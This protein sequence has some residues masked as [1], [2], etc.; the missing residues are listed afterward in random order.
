M[1]NHKVKFFKN[2]KRQAE[3]KYEPY[4]PQYQIL[5]VEPEEFKSSILP[6]GS[7]VAKTNVGNPRLK[8]PQGIEQSSIPNIGNNMEQSWTSIDGEF[9]EDLDNLTV[10]H[11][12][13]DN[14]DYINEDDLDTS[15][16]D[17]Q[18]EVEAAQSSKEESIP[19]CVLKDLKD[20]S[21]LL[22]VNGACFCSGN[23][24]EIEDQARSLVF[25][26]HPMCNGVPLSLDDI[27][28]IK[29]ASIKVGLF[30]E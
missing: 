30:V 25:G 7:L 14:N 1:S 28:V 2:S 15:D 5:G 4:V 13:I 3:D 20:Q 21:Y 9:S 19:L 11:K 8:S 26:E 17:E 23:L 10:P 12:M 24:T 16:L 6:P 29:K 18:P 22:I 27:L